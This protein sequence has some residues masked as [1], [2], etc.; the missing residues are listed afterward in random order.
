MIERK[1]LQIRKIEPLQYSQDEFCKLVR[2]DV[3]KN[4][5]QLVM[6]DST[7]GYSLSLRGESLQPRIHALTKFLQNSGIAVIIVNE[8]YSV[9]GDFTITESGISYLA[10]NIIFLRFLEIRGE[11]RKAIGVLKK[12]LGNFEK[13]LREFEITRFGIRVGE[14]LTK[15]RGILRGTPEFEN[16]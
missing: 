4:G 3:E 9:I 15:L 2:D 1:V 8:V 5:V 12:R 14:P 10:D 6:L 13:T 11:L 16:N 7:A